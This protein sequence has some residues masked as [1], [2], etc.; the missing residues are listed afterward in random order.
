M[1]HAMMIVWRLQDCLLSMVPTFMPKKKTDEAPLHFAC[2]RCDLDTAKVLVED[3]ANLESADNSR[4]TPLHIV[5]I[6][7][8]D[9]K[10]LMIVPFLC[11][12]GTWLSSFLVLSVQYSISCMISWKITCIL[13]P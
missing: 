3:G 1:T 2:N 10:I 8:S 11:E 5:C 12:N 13:G 9:L 4:V 6:K 7:D